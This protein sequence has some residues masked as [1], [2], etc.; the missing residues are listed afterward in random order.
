MQ[1]SAPFQVQAEVMDFAVADAPEVAERG[2]TQEGVPLLLVLAHVLHGQLEALLLRVPDVQ[3]EGL[4]P[5]WVH[6]PLIDVAE[7]FTN[8]KFRVK[9]VGF[10]V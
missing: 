6:G 10:R 3:E 7:P 5:G 8:S 2:Q 1:Y 9:K 4:P